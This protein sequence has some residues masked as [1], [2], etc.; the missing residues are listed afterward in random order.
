[1]DYVI[2]TTDSGTLTIPMSG[3]HWINNAKRLIGYSDGEVG[4]YS[5][6]AIC[7]TKDVSQVW[8]DS[9]HLAQGKEET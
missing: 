2:V 6:I 1:M 9:I 4:E 3:V 7:K 8:L 5:L